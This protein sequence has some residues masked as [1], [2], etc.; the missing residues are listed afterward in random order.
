M[1]QSPCCALGGLRDLLFSGLRIVLDCGARIS[2]TQR[3]GHQES[4]QKCTIR[5]GSGAAFFGRSFWSS[6]S[7]LVLSELRKRERETGAIGRSFHL[8]RICATAFRE[9]A[10]RRR[11]N[12][13]LRRRP[14]RWW[15]R[16]TLNAQFGAA[17]LPPRARRG[18][19]RGSSAPASVGIHVAGS[20]QKNRE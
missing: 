19:P 6:E 3:I 4:S 15:R 10:V 11:P 2:V 5:R 14:P 13:G 9:G 12:D 20:M 8:L 18:G 17:P 7:F 16:G 1:V